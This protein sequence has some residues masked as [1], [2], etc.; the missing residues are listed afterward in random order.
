M[1]ACAPMDDIL[2]PVPIEQAHTFGTGLSSG[3]GLE[4][5]HH[6]QGLGCSRRQRSHSSQ[7]RVLK[8]R[9]LALTIVWSQSA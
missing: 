3:A 5:V 9:L 7:V 6:S 2:R 1:A 4:A 8:N